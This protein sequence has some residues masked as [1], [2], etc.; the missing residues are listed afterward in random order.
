MVLPSGDHFTKSAP[1]ESFVSGCASPPSIESKYTCES[2]L[3]AERKAIDFPSGDQCGDESLPVRVNWIASPP[4]TGAIHK[5]LALRFASISG[6]ATVYTTH[7]PSGE[8]CTSATRCI[9]IKSSKVIAC[10]TASCA[11]AA[12]AADSNS[13]LTHNPQ[14]SPY[15]YT[16]ILM[17]SPQVRG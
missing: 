14:A 6:V 4:A 13:R 16:I 1:V 2:P 7:F 11:S 3:R 17:R 5:L 15:L 8:S 10:F 12:T 9:A